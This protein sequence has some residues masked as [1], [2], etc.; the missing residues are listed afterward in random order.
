MMPAVQL[1]P[2]LSNTVTP[3]SLAKIGEEGKISSL[4]FADVCS[5]HEVYGGNG[6]TSCRGGCQIGR[7]DYTTLVS[8]MAQV[9]KSLCF[10]IT[11]ST[12]YIRGCG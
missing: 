5:P 1:K 4:F 2:V 3:G 9:T 11:G 12:S 7:L 6:D 8:A 10:G